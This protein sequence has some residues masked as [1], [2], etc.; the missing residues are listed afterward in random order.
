LKWYIDQGVE[1]VTPYGWD[2]MHIYY[3]AENAGGLPM[4]AS[5]DDGPV[6]KEATSSDTGTN[7]QE[8]GVDEPDVVKTDGSM[9][10]RI[11]DD[12]TLVVYDVSGDEPLRVGAL[13]LDGMFTPELLLA[14]DSVVVIGRDSGAAKSRIAPGTQVWVV[15]VADPS[16]PTV[17]SKTSYDSSL[18]TARQHG[19]VVRLVVSTGLP[20]LEFVQPGLL[21]REETALERNRDI[22][23]A[24]TIDDWLPHVT[25]VE[26]LGGDVREQLVDCED[27]AIPAADA[28][29]GT[30]AVVGFDVDE[31]AA[32]DTTAVT[33]PSETV[34]MSSD[35]LYLASSPYR[36]GWQVCCW[37]LPQPGP[38]TVD[39]EGTT[40]LYD[41][42]LDGTTTTYAASGKVEGSIA[43][44]WSMDE[45]D[46]VLRVAVGPTMQTGNFNSIV[47]LSRSGSDLVESG[48]VDK[49]GVG[50]Q[51]RSMRWFDDL[52]VMVTFR[53]TDPFYAVDLTNPDEPRLLGELKIPGFSSYLH[54]IA[55]DLM[56]GMGSEADPTTGAVSGAK[57]SL[58]D[59]SDLSA[60]RELDTVV[61]PA[62]SMAQASLDP[63]QFTWLS[64]RRTALTVISEGWEGLTGYVAVLR[65]GDG[66]MTSK[67]VE[68]EYG[69]DVNDVRLVPLPDGRVVLTTG[70]SVSFFSV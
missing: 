6:P 57:A 39:D 42:D 35:H 38:A 61:Y 37:D 48:R 70:E 18:V 15:D 43:D 40:Y 47:T 69:V 25:T 63:R 23:R 58:F 67:L 20:N 19:D 46:G 55:G 45:H 2:F 5:S 59:I 51:I 9:L 4:P 14:G 12:G 66:E 53:Q 22:V 50:E 31:P 49:L 13:E 52:A 44:R 65:V 68:V 32:T 62:G 10:V 26:P 34:Y 64:D 11:V 33:T 28:G 56:I 36:L 41:F 30:V 1:R 27:V 8:S 60:P 21:R 17:V 3:M 24:T 29:L 54:P 7:V 16:S